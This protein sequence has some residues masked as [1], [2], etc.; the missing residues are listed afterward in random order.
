MEHPQTEQN[1]RRTFEDEKYQVMFSAPEIST[2]LR[3]TS[4]PTE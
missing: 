4:V 1:P 2:A 3:G